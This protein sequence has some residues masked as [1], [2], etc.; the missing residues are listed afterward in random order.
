MFQIWIDDVKI[1]SI[2]ALDRGLAY[3]DGLFA[4]MRVAN[5]KV[6]FLN[7]HLV[8]LQD[9]AERLGFFWQA[10]QNLLNELT[11][12]ASTQDNICIKLLLTRGEGGRGYQAPS[13]VTPMLI[14]SV[15]SIPDIYN[16]WHSRGVKLFSSTVKLASQPLLAGIKHLNR[17]E[18]VLIKSTQ[19]TADCDDWLVKDQQGNIVESSAGNLFFIKNK[20]VST[21]RLSFCGV[22]GV[23]RE[24]VI[25]GLL[26]QGYNVTCTDISES[27]LEK[28][29]YVLMTNSLYGIVDVVEINGKSFNRFADRQKLLKLLM[30]HSS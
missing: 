12:I 5:N 29:E 21:P 30:F 6:M 27:M 16:V 3:G 17:L 20:Q 2:S 8:R 14:V 24:Q 28:F 1:D 11:E 18:Q 15:H 7:S 22:S 26:T 13:A 25:K 10:K 9:G 4:T 19:L 23:M